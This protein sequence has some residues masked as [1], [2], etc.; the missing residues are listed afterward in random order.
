MELVP[1]REPIPPAERTPAMWAN[2]IADRV[3]DAHGDVT[4][5]ATLDH[6]NWLPSNLIVVSAKELL[7]QAMT[8]HMAFWCSNG[9]PTTTS[10]GDTSRLQTCDYLTSRAVKYPLSYWKQSKIGLLEDSLHL[11]APVRSADQRA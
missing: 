1:R 2:Q 5:L 3:A 9:L 10:T 8:P 6:K 11:V 7:T 4:K